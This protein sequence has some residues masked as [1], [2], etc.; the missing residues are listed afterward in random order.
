MYL[1]HLQ[2]PNKLAASIDLATGTG[3]SYVI[4][5]IAQIMM[6][7]GLVWAS[8]MFF[9]ARA[10]TL[11]KTSVVTPFEYA[12]LPLSAM[13]GYVIFGDVPAVPMIIGAM[14]ALS[15][16]VVKQYRFIV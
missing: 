12:S 11:A 2:L 13:G 1:H 16:V 8:G 9:V 7:L 10:Y 4:Y 5:G 6:G 3:K 14:V 15:V